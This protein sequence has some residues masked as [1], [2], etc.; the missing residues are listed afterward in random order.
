MNKEDLLR[1][2]EDT[3][4]A[5][6]D[7]L[8]SV[9]PELLV[10]EATGWRVKDIVGHIATWDNE[11][12]HALHAHRRGGEYSIP[13]FDDVDEFN[14]FA[15]RSRYAEPFDE[16]LSGWEATRSWMLI[17]IRALTPEDLTAEMTYPSG[18]HG[19]VGDLLQEIPEHEAEHLAE[20]RAAQE[21]AE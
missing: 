8:H 6:L 19:T 16:I 3:H 5:T 13:D 14:T 11:T 15:A 2:L 17:V 12:L 7:T 18:E 10:Y 9:D 20:I 21:R 4:R 1:Q